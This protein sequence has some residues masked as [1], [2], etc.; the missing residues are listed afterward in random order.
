LG[1][2]S[3]VTGEPTTVEL[4]MVGAP[5]SP[6]TLVVNPGGRQ[7]DVSSMPAS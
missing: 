1:T 5:A 6:G 3:L 4:T 7:A 2:A